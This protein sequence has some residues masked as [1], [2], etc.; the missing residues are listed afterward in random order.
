[1]WKFSVSLRESAMILKQQSFSKK[2]GDNI[3]TVTN[4]ILHTFF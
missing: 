2:L 1:M 3:V 4:N